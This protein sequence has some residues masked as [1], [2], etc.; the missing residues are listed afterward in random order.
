MAAAAAFMRR[1]GHG[2]DVDPTQGPSRAFLSP[3]GLDLGRQ[4]RG[5]VNPN[6][7][8]NAVYKTEPPLQSSEFKILEAERHVRP[9]D[10]SG[11]EQPG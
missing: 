9:V 10:V 11:V 2:S 7:L 3:N 8:A 4:A 1:V 5:S 6:T